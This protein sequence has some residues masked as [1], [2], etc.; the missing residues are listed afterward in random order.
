MNEL[1][2][3][4]RTERLAG[5]FVITA[6]LLLLVGFG[7]YLYRTAERKGWRVPRCPFYTYV[8]S[9]EGLNVGDPVVLMGFNVGE[10]T[11]ITAQPPGSWYKVYVGFEIRQPYYGYVWS[12]SKVKIAAAGLLGARRL[13][14]TPGATGAPTVY[15]ESG[16]IR[17]L[18]VDNK[19]VPFTE[20]PKGVFILPEEA[21]A[22]SERAEKLVSTVEQALPDILA[23][24]NRLN[25]VLDNS[26]TLTAS[27]TA[28]T[29]N[30]NQLVTET[31]PALTN[32]TARLDS[33]LVSA[34]TNLDVLAASLNATLLNLAD[35]TG[36]LNSQVQSN[37]QILASISKLVIDADNL[38][39]GL[40]K[41]WLLRG[42]FEKEA[43]KT[44][45]P[46]ARPSR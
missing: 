33:T 30:A 32:L 44:N 4:S 1:L 27:A 21:P 46:A 2:P 34:N 29:S 25:A 22:L 13:E 40:K 23:L 11:T 41:H 35:I 14:V 10:I 7:Y 39:Q 5:L 8:Q 37:D 18:L 42:I 45:A 26:A 20:N 24:T 9:G 19:K 6:L 31:R 36:N 12:D 38:V 28:L 3:T 16:H 15:E 43:A 17:E